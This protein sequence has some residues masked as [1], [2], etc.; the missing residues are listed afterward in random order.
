VTYTRVPKAEPRP[1][2]V[3]ARPV[4]AQPVAPE[5]APVRRARTHGRAA[6]LLTLGIALGA[7]AFAVTMAATGRSDGPGTETVIADITP[8]PAAVAAA[9]PMVVLA[10]L[11]PGSGQGPF[12][13]SLRETAAAQAARL[14]ADRARP[15]APATAAMEIPAPPKPRLRPAVAPKAATTVVAA[16]ATPDAGNRTTVS[17]LT[18]F[19]EQGQDVNANNRGSDASDSAKPAA[20]DERNDDGG[21]SGHHDKRA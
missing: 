5:R 19:I 18:A 6:W 2:A 17:S 8:P 10:S 14:A 20:R 12:D 13:A 3:S 16:A 9:T 7:A 21:N 4:R 1:A 11:P 15:P